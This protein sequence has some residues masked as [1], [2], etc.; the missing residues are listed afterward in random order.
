MPNRAAD[1]FEAIRARLRELEEERRKAQE[2]PEVP[3]PATYDYC[4]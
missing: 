4:C 2:D 1:D 3:A